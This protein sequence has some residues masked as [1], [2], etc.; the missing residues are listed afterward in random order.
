MMAADSV[1]IVREVPMSVPIFLPLV[2]G[3]LTCAA[4]AVVVIMVSRRRADT[5]LPRCGN[6]GY[7]LTGA[8]SNRCPECGELFIEAGVITRPPRP[9]P[10]RRVIWGLVLVLV[11]FAALGVLGM[12]AMSWRAR[13]ARTQ[14]IA[15][16]QAAIRAQMQAQAAT[17]Q[18]T[19]TAPAPKDGPT[20]QPPEVP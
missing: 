4:V 12:L 14:A 11:G 19:T 8:P 6:C 5:N 20:D 10:S 16:Q 9:A 17:Q 13:A 15:A 7:N 18:A 1:L 3:V 2:L